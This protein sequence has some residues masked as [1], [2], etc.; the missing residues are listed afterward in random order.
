MAVRRLRAPSLPGTSGTPRVG[1]LE[2]GVLYRR[3]AP[4]RHEL[5]RWRLDFGAESVKMG[6]LFTFLYDFSDKH[7]G[8]SSYDLGDG[9]RDLL[10]EALLN[11]LPRRRVR[12]WALSDW[13]RSCVLPFEQPASGG[14]DGDRPRNARIAPA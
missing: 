13:T 6:S 11:Y 4:G 12:I 3:D 9:H 2:T 7:L 5:G 8:E 10:A 1:G 14:H